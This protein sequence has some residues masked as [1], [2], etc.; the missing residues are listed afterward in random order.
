VFRDRCIVSCGILYPEMK[1]LMD[2]GF[3]NPHRILFT[4]PGLH[5]KPDELERQLLKRLT[6]LSES[7]PHNK[8]IVAYGKKCY[9]N[10]EEPV[11][12]VDMILQAQG[13]GIA[14]LQGDYGYDIL[15]SFEDRRRISGGREDKVLWFT[16]GWLRSWKTIYQRYF[17]WDR[18][19][20]NANFP[21]YYDKIVVLDSLGVAEEYMTEH[22]EEILE[23]FDW[24]G[25]GV[26]FHPISLDRLKSLL[27]ACAASGG[28]SVSQ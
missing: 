11:K 6:Q 16:L 24:T 4:P 25:L 2:I 13:P 15:A 14:R 18:A 7:H 28:E 12:R 1:H 26:E 20:A 23:I 9:V 5:A 8:V 17:G 10:A 27:V 3:L 21:G 22:A 19:D